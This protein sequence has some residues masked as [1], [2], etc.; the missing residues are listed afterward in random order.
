MTG[1]DIAYKVE[2]L[3]IKSSKLRSLTFA[4]YM[5]LYECES[6]DP[7]EFIGAYDV[8]EDLVIDLNR[9]LSLLTKQAFEALRSDKPDEAEVK[10]VSA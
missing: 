4:L 5:A 2:E 9:E 3:E 10:A 8:L 7:A 6:A 1:H